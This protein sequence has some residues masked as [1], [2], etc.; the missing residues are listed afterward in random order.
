[1]R[2]IAGTARGMN[3]F[4]P[5]SELRPTMDMVKGAMFSSLGDKIAGARVLD[6]FSGSGSLGIEALS[7]G[8][9]SAVLVE[10]NSTA[11]DTIRRNLAKAKLEAKVCQLDV[12]NYLTRVALPGEFDIIFA[13]P[14]YAK[15]T[16]DRDFG[17]ELLEFPALA[18]AL[19]PDGLFI[20]EQLPGTG[21][22]EDTD[23]ECLRL[24]RYGATEVAVLARRQ[25]EAS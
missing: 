20:L 16:D 15:K 4:I 14:P 19:A 24:K 17:R 13:D 25:A 7:R 12:F 1:M 21:S 10:K 22:H 8:C 9:A 6:L 5:K 11:V 3:L 18:K 2:I 23:W